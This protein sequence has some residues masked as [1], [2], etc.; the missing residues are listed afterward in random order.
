[1]LEKNEE[2][3]KTINIARWVGHHFS[4]GDVIKA[5]CQLEIAWGVMTSPVLFSAP[6]LEIW[7]H[8]VAKLGDCCPWPI[9]PSQL[10]EDQWSAETPSYWFHHFYGTREFWI[11]ETFE[12]NASVLSGWGSWKQLVLENHRAEEEW[13]RRQ[14]ECLSQD[15]V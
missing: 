15:C 8:V 9:D 2:H 11:G 6:Q 1:M 10:T 4:S 12:E 7:R 13:V 3:F 14:N 5:E